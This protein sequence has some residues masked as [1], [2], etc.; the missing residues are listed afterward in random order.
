M[1]VH[2]ANRLVQQMFV[3]HVQGIEGVARQSATTQASATT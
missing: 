3:E 2:E 1:Y